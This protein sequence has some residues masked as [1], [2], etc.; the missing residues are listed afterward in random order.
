[1]IVSPGYRFRLFSL[2]ACMLT[3]TLTEA[4]MVS[5][6]AHQDKLAPGESKQIKITLFNDKDQT[7]IVDLK[8][9]DYSCNSQGQ[10]FY[11]TCEPQARSNKNWITL[12]SDRI[13]LNPGDKT[14]VHY[15]VNV[16]RDEALKGSYWSVLLIEPTEADP[17]EKQ[18]AEGYHLFVKIRFAYHIVTDVSEGIR[19]LK[20]VQKEI[21]EVNGNK[22]LGIDIANTGEVFQ[23]PL[24][25]LKLYNKEGDLKN[26]LKAQSERL[27]PGNSQRYLLN[28]QDVPSNRYTA[29]MLLDN[30]DQ[31]MFGDSFELTIP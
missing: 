19:K 12:S 4:L 18:S 13:S 9:C 3:T 30:G 31:H 26:T 15:T 11:E 27:Y 20:V 23:N 2:C 16:P 24:L 10:H 1:M 21:Q 14:N 6:L 8:L 29:F 28:I 25:T 22:Y 7:E 17:P 5:E